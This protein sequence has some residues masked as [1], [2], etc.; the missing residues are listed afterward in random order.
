MKTR[1][2]RYLVHI[3]FGDDLDAWPMPEDILHMILEL[4]GLIRHGSRSASFVI[5][6][7][8]RSLRFLQKSTEPS[9]AQASEEKSQEGGPEAKS[10][11]LDQA[12]HEDVPIEQ[13]GRVLRSDETR[14]VNVEEEKEVSTG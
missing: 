8:R 12:R 13:V 5:W 3:Y 6:S 11:S 4:S 10:I 9:D 2:N 1:M 7:P 14:E